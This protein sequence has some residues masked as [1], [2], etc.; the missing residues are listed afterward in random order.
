MSAASERDA[1]YRETATER[2][3]ARL[4]P[5]IANSTLKLACFAVT[6]NEPGMCEGVAEETL[7][8]ECLRLSEE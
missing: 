4:C 8:E 7:K 2:N 1:C 5:R 6:T 3:D